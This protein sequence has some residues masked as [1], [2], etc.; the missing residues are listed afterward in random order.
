MAC[1]IS[2]NPD[3]EETNDNGKKGKKKGKE[4]AKVDLKSDKKK[5]SGG[6]KCII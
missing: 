3:E 4:D 2:F 1:V 6:K 5:S